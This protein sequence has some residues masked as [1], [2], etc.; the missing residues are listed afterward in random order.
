MANDYGCRPSELLKITDEWDALKWDLAIWTK[1]QLLMIEE[2]KKGT[3]QQDSVES[4]VRQVH[5]NTFQ[6]GNVRLPAKARNTTEIKNI[7]SQYKR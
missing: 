2:Q 1:A 5:N 7:L 4:R 6:P 3:A